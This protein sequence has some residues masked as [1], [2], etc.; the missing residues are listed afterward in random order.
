MRYSGAMQTL[1]RYLDPVTKR[2]GHPAGE[3]HTYK[4]P[5]YILLLP[6][7]IIRF[8]VT[9]S[10]SG[11][12]CCLDHISVLPCIRQNRLRTRGHLRLPGYWV[13]NGRIPIRC[14]IATWCLSIFRVPSEPAFLEKS[15]QDF[16]H[17]HFLAERFDEVVVEG[18][19]FGRI[20]DTYA[21]FVGLNPLSYAPGTTD[22]LVQQGSDAFWI[23]EAGSERRTATDL[24]MERIR[25]N[26]V[27]YENGELRYVSAGR[28]AK[29]GIPG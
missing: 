12:R 11:M 1:G 22:D 7:L 29:P 16:T 28:G 18:R 19:C 17:S 10:I 27:R 9:S 4:S 6:R 24:F 21:A 26:E 8:S 13:G 20:G 5:E 2:R 25:S 15:V 14:S 3:Y 23:F